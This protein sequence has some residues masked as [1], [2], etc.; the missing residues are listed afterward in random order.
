MKP[1]LFLRIASVLTFIHAALHTIGGVFGKPG[2]GAAS[3][4]FAAMQANQFMVYGLPRTY[5]E[6]YRGM[7]L[8][9]TISMTAEA[10]LFWQLGSLARTLAARLRPIIA[11]FAVAYLVIAVNSWCY[12][13][14]APVVVEVLI[15]L[16][17]VL[18]IVTAKP[19][20]SA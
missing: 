3:V 2:P 14:Q 7:G 19:A 18:A 20:A 4:A 1:T 13:F 11:A 8:A 15:A 17:L 5:A 12:F 16:C 6:F 10:F 9:M